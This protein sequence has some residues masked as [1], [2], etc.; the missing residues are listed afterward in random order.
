MQKTAVFCV[1]AH[2]A[3]GGY[4]LTKKCFE[5]HFFQGLMR[6]AALRV[7]PPVAPVGRYSVVQDSFARLLSVVFPDHSADVFVVCATR[8]EV[9][10][11]V[12]ELTHCNYRR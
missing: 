3:R 6:G 10:E 7:R 9:Q 5:M 12:E 4:V 2:T 11:G 1:S 8:S